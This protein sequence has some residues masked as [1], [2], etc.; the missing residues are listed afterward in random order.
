M[1]LLVRIIMSHHRDTVFNPNKGVQAIKFPKKL[2]GIILS[3]DMRNPPLYSKSSNKNETCNRI[4]ITT[5]S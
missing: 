2:K 4:C 5:Y 3:F 1:T